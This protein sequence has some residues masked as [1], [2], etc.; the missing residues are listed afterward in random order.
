MYG[1]VCTAPVSLDPVTDW[2]VGAGLG[3]VRWN[4][5]S[6]LKAETH[7]CPRR[8]SSWTHTHTH[9]NR[10]DSR[11]C[12]LLLLSNELMQFK[13][14]ASVTWEVLTG[15]REQRRR[16][17]KPVLKY[18]SCLSFPLECVFL[19]AG[20]SF[21]IQGKYCL[22]NPKYIKSWFIDPL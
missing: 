10:S 22:R 2:C 21:M 8:S 20:K 15:K 7:S 19:S 5:W 12:R 4:A 11:G 16:H 17:P 9:A 14:Q 13:R 3:D 18:T 1:S 6:R